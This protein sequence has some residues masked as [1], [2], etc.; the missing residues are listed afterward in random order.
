M[1]GPKILM[2]VEAIQTE[3]HIDPEV[4]F[5]GI[6]AAIMAAA[7]KLYG[8]EAEITVSIDR[9]NGEPTVVAE[10]DT[11][12]PNEIGELIGRIG[13]QTAKQVIIQKVRE[14]ERDTLYDEYADLETQVVTGTVVRME[15]GSA[16]VS[17][18]KAE[19]ILPRSEMIPGETH[20]ANER[21]RA[22]VLEVAKQGSKLKIILSRRHTDFVRRLFEIEIPE[23]SEHVIEIRSL[24]R[25][26]GYRSKVAVS[27][28]D[29]KVDAIGACVGVR[30]S[31]IR[32]IIDELG[33]ER[34]DIVR[35]NDSLQVLVPN[36]LEP[37]KVEDVILCPM[38]GKVIVLVHEEELSLAI[39]KKG[40][41]VRL[42]S[43]LVG[44]DI[45]VLT[46]ERLD[47]QIDKTLEQFSA[48]PY[49]SEELIEKLIEEG[50]FTFDDLSVIEPDFL[51]E[52]SG[53]PDDQCDTIV[54]YADKMAEEFEKM[55]EAVRQAERDARRMGIDL[56]DN[57]RKQASKP[58]SSGRT[59]SRT[60]PICRRICDSRN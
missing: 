35:W 51:S 20:R 5:D 23:V 1:D 44:W 8:E 50:F 21:L 33:G 31:R 46:Q 15:R 42:G 39:G 3:K 16:I 12:D 49:M 41:N 4:V 30:G 40:Q 54:E 13:A 14:A 11:L 43:K 48:V 18:G 56:N 9:S 45:D 25:E 37:A 55:E 32:N 58:G 57:N 2:M 53:L 6:E 22:V 29:N 36:A 60:V 7:R 59:C 34:I 17:I 24:A 19:A 52:L 47:E 10:G 26:A 28:Y 38:L 27:C